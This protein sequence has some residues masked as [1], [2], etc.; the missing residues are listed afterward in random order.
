M[1]Q[2]SKWVICLILGLMMIL[3]VFGYGM[4]AFAAEPAGHGKQADEPAASFDANGW[5]TQNAYNAMADKNDVLASGTALIGQPGDGYLGYVA[6]EGAGGY[7]KMASFAQGKV[8]N[9]NVLPVSQA[10][11]FQIGIHNTSLLY[12]KQKAGR[13]YRIAP[14]FRGQ[15]REKYKNIIT[16]PTVF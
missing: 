7:T 13:A 16:D 6:P 2:R 5:F 1:K 11:N 15:K 12:I 3:S 9:N 10:I 14:P 4:L 8:L